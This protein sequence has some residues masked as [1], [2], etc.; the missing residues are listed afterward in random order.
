MN[1]QAIEEAIKNH[2]NLSHELIFND[3]GAALLV[4]DGENLPDS[5]TTMMIKHAISYFG[6]I[7]KL[8]SENCLIFSIQ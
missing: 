5:Y 1:E 7:K 8:C 4:F 3:S 2:T 6:V